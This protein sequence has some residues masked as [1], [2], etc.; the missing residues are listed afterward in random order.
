MTEFSGT[1]RYQLVRRLGAG[2]MGIVYEAFDRERSELVALK[3][4]SRVDPAGIYDLKKE[5]RSLADVRHTNVVSLYD[6]VNEAGFWFFTMELVYGTPFSEFVA[7]AGTGRDGAPSSARRRGSDDGNEPREDA[8]LLLSQTRADPRASASLLFEE[9]KLRSALGQLV[10]GVSAIHAAGKLHR[11]LKP[12]N[13]LIT[14]E[15]RVVVLDFG[16]VQDDSRS[17]DTA[18]TGRP[19]VFL[20]WRA[21]DGL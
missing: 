17:S 6:I 8:A 13:V 9:A 19:R 5:F 15:G 10:L 11:D 12:S 4:L 16:L 20:S 21:P 7:A 2:G 18:D 3:T 14:R 1:D